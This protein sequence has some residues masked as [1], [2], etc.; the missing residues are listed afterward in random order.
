V[1]SC[2]GPFD[3]HRIR[4]RTECLALRRHINKQLSE[5][6]NTAVRFR[7]RRC[8]ASRGMATDAVVDLYILSWKWQTNHLT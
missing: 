3:A 7:K 4:N 5:V 6:R 8:T 2:N 1:V